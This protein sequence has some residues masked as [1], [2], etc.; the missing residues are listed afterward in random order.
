ML[1]INKLE[2]DHSSE[3]FDIETK[4]HEYPWSKDIFEQNFTERHINL[5][6]Y[7]Q[8]HLVGFCLCQFILD[9][10]SIFNI[11][12]SP[13]F[14]NKGVGSALLMRLLDE[15]AI[16]QIVNVWLEVRESNHAAIAL[17][18]KLGFNQVSKRVGYYPK[19]NLREDAL[20][21]ALSLSM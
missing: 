12:V 1:I 11:A 15:L 8:N 6:A 14:Q 19:G 13:D 20:V 18:E 2:L 4:A 21:M 3:A 17:Y 16:H 7:Q 9:E 5:G 10:A